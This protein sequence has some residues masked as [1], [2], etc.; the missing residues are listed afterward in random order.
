MTDNTYGIKISREK[1]RTINR[2]IVYKLDRISRTI[3][4]SFHLDFMSI[5]QRTS[6][7]RDNFIIYQKKSSCNS[8]GFFICP[9]VPALE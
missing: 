7:P 5:I 4:I 6:S 9:L 3:A 8:R 1:S 2:V